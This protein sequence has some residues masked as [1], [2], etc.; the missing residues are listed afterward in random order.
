LK[1]GDALLERYSARHLLRNLARANN[2]DDEE[3][4]QAGESLGYGDQRLIFSIAA[5]RGN[6]GE[7]GV[8]TYPFSLSKCKMRDPLLKTHLRLSST[9]SGGRANSR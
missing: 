3:I 2:I 7:H 1:S 9:T 6:E 5:N 4:I 8:V